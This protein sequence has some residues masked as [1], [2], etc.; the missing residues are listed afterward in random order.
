MPKDTSPETATEGEQ[1]VGDLVSA[2]RGALNGPDDPVLRGAGFTFDEL[3]RGAGG[4]WDQVMQ[5][6]LDEAGV[7]A[8]AQLLTDE[9]AYE[10]QVGPDESYDY[11]LKCGHALLRLLHT[12]ATEMGVD[13]PL[14]QVDVPLSPSDEAVQSGLFETVEGGVNLTDEG[15]A[16]AREVTEQIDALKE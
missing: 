6:P 4:G 14:E 3:Q 15:R 12:K 8:L 13:I 11:T 2:L 16:A 9:I 5:W 10:L 1:T 7:L